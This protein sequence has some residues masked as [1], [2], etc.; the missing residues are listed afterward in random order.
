MAFAV[1]EASRSGRK[2]GPTPL[3]LAEAKNTQWLTRRI[4]SQCIAL[5]GAGAG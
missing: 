4:V 2:S 5:T 1:P 3:P